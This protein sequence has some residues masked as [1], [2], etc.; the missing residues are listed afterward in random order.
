MNDLDLFEDASNPLDSI[1]DVFVAN[2]WAF[3]RAT[4]DELTVHVTAKLGQYNLRFVWFEHENAMQ[5]TCEID[6]SIQDNQHDFAAKTLMA[7]NS[8]LWMGHFSICDKTGS[9][10][11]RHTSLLRGMMYSTGADHVEV[12][13]DNAIEACERYYPVFLILSG[14]AE[15]NENT[16]ALAMAE[17]Y[18]AA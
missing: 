1:E 14:Q 16:M 4:D 7:I 10:I 6:Q 12:L 18:G 8:V 13:I 5:F 3:D 17:S 9:L 11:F 2:D 15:C